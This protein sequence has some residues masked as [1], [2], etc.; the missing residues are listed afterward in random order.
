MWF[1]DPP[2]RERRAKGDFRNNVF[3]KARSGAYAYRNIQVG[4]LLRKPDWKNIQLQP[5]E[6]KLYKEHP[7]T[8]S[9]SMAKVNA[10]RNVNGIS[11]K[12]NNV[13]KPILS[14]E[15]CNFPDS[16]VESIE[17]L[18]DHTSPTPIE[19]HCWPIALTCRTF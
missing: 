13:P 9:R 7:A 10:Y 1:W 14:L 19:A 16:I 8:R 4:W 3:R 6:K 12:G 11:V 2:P 17:T 18:R 5:F 15:E